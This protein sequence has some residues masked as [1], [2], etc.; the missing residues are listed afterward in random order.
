MKLRRKKSDV[1]P[2]ETAQAVELHRWLSSAVLLGVLVMIPYSI[3]LSFRLPVRFNAHNWDVAWVGFDS[4][5]IVV[6]A[7]TAWA[8]WNRR[9]ILAATSIIAGTMLVCDAWFDVTTSLGTRD[10]LASILSGIFLNVPLALFFF[11]LAR[12]IM[13]RSAAVLAMALSSGAVPQRA[14]EVPM[15]FATTW[16]E[17]VVEPATFSET[18]P[19]SHD[20]V[21]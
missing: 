11:S 5:L 2:G 20:G 3:F 10:Q 4:A 8:A 17:Q 14:H 21:S 7:A 9:Q 16:R 19:E 15:P 12:R 1:T 18:P 6:L 13:L